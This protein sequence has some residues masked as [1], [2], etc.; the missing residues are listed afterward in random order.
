MYSCHASHFFTDEAWFPRIVFV[1]S[2]NTRFWTTNNLNT[3]L[4]F[5]YPSDKKKNNCA[6]IFACSKF[7]FIFN[8]LHIIRY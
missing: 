8:Y 6:Y 1:N 7:I 2:Q 4:A 3:F 5:L